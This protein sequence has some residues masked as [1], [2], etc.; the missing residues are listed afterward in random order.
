MAELDFVVKRD[1]LARSLADYLSQFDYG[2][3]PTMEDIVRV[4]L[5]DG[6][7]WSARGIRLMVA[8]LEREGV[9]QSRW[10]GKAWVFWSDI[11]VGATKVTAG[12]AQGVVVDVYGTNPGMIS[13]DWDQHGP[14]RDSVWL[15]DVTVVK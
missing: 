6:V 8:A 2:I 7:V 12:S 15:C 3:S 1:D 14:Q 11:K 10:D 13:V 4:Y 9:L 5:D